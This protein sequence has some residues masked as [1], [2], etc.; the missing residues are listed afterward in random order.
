MVSTSTLI[1]RKVASGQ[2]QSGGADEGVNVSELE[3]MLS[4]AGGGAAAIYGLNRGSLL[5]TAVGGSLL[6]RAFSGHCPMYSALDVSTAQR[7]TPAASVPAG[8]GFK[9]VRAATIN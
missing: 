3:R 1:G 9:V 7:H 6:Y 4:L 8:E 5:L 2:V